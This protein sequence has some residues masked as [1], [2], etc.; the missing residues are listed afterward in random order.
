M[1]GMTGHIARSWHCDLSRQGQHG[2]HSRGVLCVDR[3]RYCHV[4]ACGR[5]TAA[6]AVIAQHSRIAAAN[7]SSAARLTQRS[8]PPPS[9]A[10]PSIAT[11]GTSRRPRTARGRRVGDQ[12]GNRH[13]EDRRGQI[14]HR[15][16]ASNGILA[17]HRHC[18]HV[19]ERQP[20]RQVPHRH[21]LRDD[22]RND[23]DR[24]LCRGRSRQEM[25]TMLWPP[26]RPS[27]TGHRPPR[28]L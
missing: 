21:D 20:S 23:D 24:C 1:R 3:P 15:K 26:Q 10:P 17:S 18:Q 13:R 2:P 6:H 5:R 28:Q 25:T 7:Q 4:S 27:A 12:A 8:R 9:S 16:S 14:R 11:I 19:D 22:R